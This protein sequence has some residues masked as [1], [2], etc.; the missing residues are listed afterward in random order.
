VQ[1]VIHDFSFVLLFMNKD[2][3]IEKTV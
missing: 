3:C 2:F 1:L